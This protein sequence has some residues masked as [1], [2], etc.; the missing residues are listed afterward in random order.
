VCRKYI[1]ILHRICFW[2]FASFAVIKYVTKKYEQIHQRQSHKNLW[3][4]LTVEYGT[5]STYEPNR[6]C[7]LYWQILQIIVIPKPKRCLQTRRAQLVQSTNMLFLW[8]FIPWPPP[9]YL[10]PFIITN[11]NMFNI[12]HNW[13]SVVC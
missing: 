10:L 4:T 6:V 5:I 2:G 7:V 8:Q 9:L 11:P 3:N 13:Y 1:D 12:R